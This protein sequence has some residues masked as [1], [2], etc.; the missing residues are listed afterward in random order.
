MDFHVSF[1]DLHSA[2]A[3]IVQLC[4]A[5]CD[6]K[7]GFRGTCPGTSGDYFKHFSDLVYS[8]A[9]KL[10]ITS[11]LRGSKFS[12]A[13]QHLFMA[14]MKK[15]RSFLNQLSHCSQH[16][17]LTWFT[18]EMQSMRHYTVESPRIC[19]DWRQSRSP[20]SAKHAA[21]HN[22]KGRASLLLT[23]LPWPK[24]NGLIVF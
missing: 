11:Q 8:M 20:I 21:N 10:A 19:I 4:R 16:T 7:V 24:Y 22:T 12:I 13:L 23:V 1:T 18:T 2:M 9:S 6:D 5:G 3:F 14:F 15:G 17:G